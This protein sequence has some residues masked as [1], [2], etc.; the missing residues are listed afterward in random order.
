MRSWHPV[1]M[2]HKVK[3]HHTS[4]YNTSHH[5]II[6]FPRHWGKCVAKQIKRH[7]WHDNVVHQRSVSH[8]QTR[9]LWNMANIH[10]LRLQWWQIL[11][12]AVRLR[13]A[14]WERSG[15]CSDSRAAAT[16]HSL[17]NWGEK[18]DQMFS[19]FLLGPGASHPG[20]VLG[21][22]QRAE[23]SHFTESCPESQIQA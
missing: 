23:S 7:I 2:L 6:M 11:R 18:Q 3:W 17:V 8:Q 22:F 21:N 13:V 9:L 12:G 19:L 10:F 4:Q 1:V 16:T 14:S 5:L 15:G 20:R